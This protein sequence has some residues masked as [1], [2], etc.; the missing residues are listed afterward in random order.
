V[1]ASSASALSIAPYGI[2]VKDRDILDSNP[3]NEISQVL[4]EE[5]LNEI[6]NS[7]KEYPEN[8]PGRS[9]RR[10][11]IV[12]I[13]PYKYRPHIT[14]F[15][16]AVIEESPDKIL[17]DEEYPVIL[18]GTYGRHFFKGQDSNGKKIFGIHFNHFMAGIYGGKFFTGKFFKHR[19]WMQFEEDN[20]TVQGRFW[21]F[22]F[23]W[24]W[25]NEAENLKPVAITPNPPQDWSEY[26]KYKEN[27]VQPIK[28]PFSKPFTRVKTIEKPLPVKTVNAIQRINKNLEKT[29]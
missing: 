23:H 25:F 6:I 1:I 10:P 29:R 16:I 14:G 12:E 3:L 17:T 21:V 11:G 13:E 2:T 18:W 24:K 20:R 7:V 4:G 27:Q 8:G 28:K 5:E 9:E 15:F 22:P 19:F 26:R